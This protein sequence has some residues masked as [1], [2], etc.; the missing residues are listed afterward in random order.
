MVMPLGIVKWVC[1]SCEWAKVS[2]EKSDVLMRRVCQKCGN[3]NLR[4]EKASLA[5]KALYF[6]AKN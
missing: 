4:L 2:N 5:E 3:P 1:S 6:F